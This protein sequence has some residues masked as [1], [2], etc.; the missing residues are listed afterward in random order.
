MSEGTETGRDNPFRIDESGSFLQRRS[1]I[2]PRP[3]QKPRPPRPPFSDSPSSKSSSHTLEINMGRVC[4]APRALNE[5]IKSAKK[6][7][8]CSSTV[9]TKMTAIPAAQSTTTARPPAP[10]PS[11]TALQ[12]AAAPNTSAG[13]P[14]IPPT[15]T[16][17]NVVDEPKFSCCGKWFVGAMDFHNHLKSGLHIDTVFKQNT[18]FHCY[19][20]K[21]FFD[22]DPQTCMRHLNDGKV[23]KRHVNARG[24]I[25]NFF[26]FLQ[27]F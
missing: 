11:T 27:F 3:S 10:R 7:G 5:K 17:D 22:Q 20:W 25:F 13:Q 1:V 26:N 24:E 19:S 16:A 4:K 9:P 23:H 15:T 8:E 18:K 12:Q 21:R 2:Q 14:A 6:N